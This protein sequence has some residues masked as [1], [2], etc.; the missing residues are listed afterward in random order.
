MSKEMACCF[1]LYFYRTVECRKALLVNCSKRGR[2]RT[3]KLSRDLAR[4]RSIVLY[5]NHNRYQYIL[6]R[7]FFLVKRAEGGV[8]S[9]VRVQ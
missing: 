1:V 8:L 6:Q 3:S 9:Q 5:Y 2:T 4:A 7:F